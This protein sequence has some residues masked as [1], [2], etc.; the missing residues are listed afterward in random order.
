M[1]YYRYHPDANNY[2]GI[3]LRPE[4]RDVIKI[5]HVT[6]PIADE[7]VPVEV[8][9]IEDNPSTHGDFPSL[10]NYNMIPVMSLRAWDALRPLIGYCCE[11]LPIIHPSGKPYYIIHVMETI[12]ALDEE[13]SE[14]S[15]NRV[16]GRV[17]AVYRYALRPASLSGKHIFKL[18]LESGDEL[19]VDDAF[20]QAVVQ[21]GLKGLLFNPIPL[22]E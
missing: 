7:W 14:L 11:A 21:H 2:A 8:L 15:R 20:R 16:T 6:S 3:M 5:R 17:S 13:R 9:D 4:D 1:Y 12:D 18:P 10:V 19:L 22:V